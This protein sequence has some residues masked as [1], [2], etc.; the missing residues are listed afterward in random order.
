MEGMCSHAFPVLYTCTV[1]WGRA[2][3]VVTR[4]KSEDYYV[5]SVVQDQGIAPRPVLVHSGVALLAINPQ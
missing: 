2:F 1:M 3:P 5:V 4:A